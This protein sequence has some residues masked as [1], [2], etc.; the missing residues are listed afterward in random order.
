[1]LKS[2]GGQIATPGGEIVV[3]AV[4]RAVPALF[5]AAP[6]IGRKEHPVMLETRAKISQDAGQFLTRNVKEGG[7]GEDAVKVVGRK[8][9][10]KE[11]LTKNLTA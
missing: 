9:K 8:L 1:M 4:A 11:I 2:G 3:T 5:V 6:G 10:G 7:V